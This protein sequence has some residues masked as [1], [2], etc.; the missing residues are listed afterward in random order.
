MTENRREQNLNQ[1]IWLQILDSERWSR[2]Y[3]QLAMRHRRMHSWTTLAI[4]FTSLA[5]AFLAGASAFTDM[6]PIQV[7]SLVFGFITGFVVAYFLH[8]NDARVASQAEAAS[9]H[10]SLMGREWRYVWN[11]RAEGEANQVRVL[12][13]RMRAG[14]NVDID[15]DE[16]LHQE[17]HKEAIVIM[18]K[19]FAVAA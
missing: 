2:Y 13:E 10:F 6:V 15:D 12:L 11:N 9:S 14:P 18:E 5:T 7:S 16:V 3:R 1:E 4:G 19:E 8:Q 17:C